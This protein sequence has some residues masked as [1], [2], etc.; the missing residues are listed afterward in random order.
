MN[1]PWIRSN[2]ILLTC[3][4]MAV[5]LVGVLALLVV[6]QQ[7]HLAIDDREG[8]V[9]GQTFQWPVLHKQAR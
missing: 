6:R 5:V 7:H 8:Q 2:E 3:F 4:V 9:S 1:S